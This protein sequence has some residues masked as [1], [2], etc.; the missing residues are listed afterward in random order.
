MEFKT[1]L[2][3]LSLILSSISFFYQISYA[4]VVFVYL[5]VACDINS[6]GE[7]EHK[8]GHCRH[9]WPSMPSQIIK[10]NIFAINSSL[11]VTN[12]E[13]LVE[14]WLLKV[15][16]AEISWVG[17]C[18]EVWEKRHFMF[19]E[20]FIGL[21]FYVVSDDILSNISLIQMSFFRHVQC[22]KYCIL[23]SHRSFPNH[24]WW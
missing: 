17:A 22:W 18:F 20:M 6:F 3:F 9:T 12:I 13:T 19:E 5:H 2:N 15:S 14:F 23:F 21:N 8:Q 4:H 24:K 16:M 10:F 1:L 7:S 11:I